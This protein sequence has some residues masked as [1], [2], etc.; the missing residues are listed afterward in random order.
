MSHRNRGWLA[1]HHMDTGWCRVVGIGRWPACLEHN[2]HAAN[3]TT[4]TI[5]QHD[6]GHRRILLWVIIYSHGKCCCG[7]SYRVRPIYPNVPGCR[8]NR[9]RSH[10]SVARR[11]TSGAQCQQF[12]DCHQSHPGWVQWHVYRAR[13]NN[14][15][16]H[17]SEHNNWRGRR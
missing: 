15:N 9:F 7:P 10:V 14:H 11:I 13:L 17:C 8:H 5:F 4:C 1:R 2:G 12:C 16:G 3:I 6:T